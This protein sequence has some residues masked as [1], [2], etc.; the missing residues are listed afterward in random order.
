M[1]AITGHI[2]TNNLWSLCCIR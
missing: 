2:L 1:H